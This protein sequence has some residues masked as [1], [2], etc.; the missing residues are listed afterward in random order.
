MVFPV[1]VDSYR[2]DAGGNRNEIDVG[3]IRPGRCQRSSKQLL[4]RSLVDSVTA[5]A[6]ID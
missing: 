5:L 2:F 1:F 6:M 4:R 3:E